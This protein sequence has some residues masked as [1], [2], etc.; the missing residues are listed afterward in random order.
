LEQLEMETLAPAV[1]QV[2]RP[3]KPT[4]DPALAE[5][6]RLDV[7]VG[8]HKGL[9]ALM[10]H[11]LVTVGRADPADPSE[12]AATLDEVRGL[13]AVCA[14]HLAH[15]NKHIHAAMEARRPD[16]AAHTADDH[17]DHEHA[18]ARL[19]DAVRVVEQ[20]HGSL[21][22]A[23]ALRLYRQLAVFVA[24]NLEHMHV[25]ET[26]NNA[27]LWAEYSDD[28][29][30][31]IHDAILADVAPQEMARIVRWIVPFVTPAERA[32]MF[33]EMS[34][35]APPEVVEGLLAIVKP[36]LTE[37]DWVKLIAAIAPGPL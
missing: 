22:A 20:S 16:S 2:A 1:R 14:S 21:R 8:V 7:Y 15:E 3:Q 30:A 17:L 29:I 37:R 10:S 24:E 18:I 9:R 5:R 35:K 6:P 23:A 28:E 12:L 33:S 11:V 25:E 36:H 32:A 31:K 26:E 34:R 13:L 4:R 27:V 19:E